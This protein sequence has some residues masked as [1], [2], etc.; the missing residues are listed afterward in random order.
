MSLSIAFFRGIKWQSLASILSALTQFILLALLAREESAA[1]FGLWAIALIFVRLAMPFTDFGISNAIVQSKKIMPGQLGTIYI[2]QW[3]L[4]IILFSLTQLFGAWFTEEILGLKDAFALISILSWVFLIAPI[5]LIHTSGIRKNLQFTL[6]GKIN[7]FAY[8]SELIIG[9]ILILNGFSIWSLVYVYLFR[10]SIIA[11]LSLINSPWNFND[12]L[13]KKL[14]WPSDM[15]QF[16]FY[17]FAG[18]WVNQWSVQLDKILVGKFLGPAALGYYMLAWDLVITPLGKISGLINH[19]AFPIY[20]QI[21]D[22]NARLGK[23]YHQISSSIWW[24]GIPFLAILFIFNTPIIKLIYGPGW[25]SV[26]PL[27][28]ILCVAAIFKLLN[29]PGSAILL[30]KG[31]SD[32]LLQ[33]NLLWLFV[34]GISVWIGL[35]NGA[36]LQTVIWIQVVAAF[37]LSW[38]WH[39]IIARDGVI[40]YRPFFMYVGKGLLYILPSI[41]VGTTLS[42]L[43]PNMPWITLLNIFLM[44]IIYLGMI[45]RFEKNT[46]LDVKE[47]I[48]S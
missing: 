43:L 1:D 5:G 29:Y 18:S 42:T 4:G 25:E 17:D 37:S 11:L 16:A 31:H 34:L 30:S 27:V 14:S 8:L 3:I 24:I 32:R 39:W 12:F 9:I 44:L 40:N 13:D 26:G 45:W 20:S 46:I 15:M 23:I 22:E 21:Q 28:S 41:V 7:S 10:Y 48:L 6:W 19:I 2:V 36:L 33:W 38:I 35:A 47:K